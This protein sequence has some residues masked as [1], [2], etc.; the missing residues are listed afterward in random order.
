[1]AIVSLPEPPPTPFIRGRI[2]DNR[3]DI[4]EI[5]RLHRHP[6]AAAADA[7]LSGNWRANGQ[8]IDAVLAS[9]A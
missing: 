3:S 7:R 8:I 5:Q 1:M 4:K 9:S 2:D 6:A